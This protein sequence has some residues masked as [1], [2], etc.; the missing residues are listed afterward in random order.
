MAWSSPRT[1][2]DGLLVGADDLNVDLRD[3]L[4]HLKV[5]IDNNGKLTALSSTYLADL[6]GVNLTGVL[7]LA[8]DN[9]FTAGDQSFNAGASTRLVLP[10]GAD[11][12]AT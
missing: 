12:W 5:A 1:W 3:N 9:D 7:R 11:R 6:S 4:N 10:V 8:A 2:T